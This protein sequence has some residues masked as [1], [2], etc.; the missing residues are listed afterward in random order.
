MTKA[1]K[2]AR[3]IV[4]TCLDVQKNESML[5]LTTENSAEEAALLYEA[6]VAKTASSMLVQIPSVALKKG[7]PDAVA[8]LM[9]K[10]QIVIALTAPSISHTEAR[11]S[12]CRAG[13]R[14]ASMPSVS[15]EA[16]GRIADADWAAIM[17]RSRKLADILSMASKVHITADNGT[18]LTLSLDGRKGYADTGL[19]HLPGSFSNLPAG[20]AAAAPTD[21]SAEGLLIV[22]SGMGIRREEGEQICIVIK[23]GRAVRINGGGAARKLSRNLT[24]Y[25]PS[26]RMIAEFGIGTNEAAKLSGCTVEDEKVL[27]TIHIALGNN[28]SFG[29]NNDVP[30]HLDGVVVNATVEVDG[31]VI[32][33]RGNLLV[34]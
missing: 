1:Q 8:D 14:I 4:G 21:G 29:G 22:D 16:F 6:A 32:L 2:A 18:D 28:R 12:A 15:P 24:L 27:G 3:I 26:S 23:R 13:C 30:V 11:R 7:L 33:E 5:I 34:G 31:K 25:G 20:E 17:R 9:Q 19:L 10:M